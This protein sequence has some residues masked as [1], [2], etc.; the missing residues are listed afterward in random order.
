MNRQGRCDEAH[1]TAAQALFGPEF[2]AAGPSTNS[3]TTNVRRLGSCRGRVVPA[4]EKEAK[5]WSAA[6]KF[7][8]VMNTIGLNTTGLRAHCR[9]WV[10]FP[11]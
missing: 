11:K 9:E 5:G 8:V 6:E 10:Q 7:T 3:A 1:E 4:S 2:R